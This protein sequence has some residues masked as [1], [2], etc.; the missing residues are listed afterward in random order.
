MI[1]KIT[2]L[3]FLLISSIYAEN[4]DFE[5][6]EEFQNISKNIENNEIK[7]QEGFNKE[8]FIKV[9]NG[10]IQATEIRIAILKEQKSCVLNSSNFDDLIDCRNNAVLGLKKQIE[11]IK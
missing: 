11:K 8:D 1:K 5:L 3:T 10:V 4:I 2:T 6:S 9:K 7:T